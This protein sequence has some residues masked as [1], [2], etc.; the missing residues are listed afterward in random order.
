MQAVRRLRISAS[1]SALFYGSPAWAGRFE[2]HLQA[3]LNINK[4]RFVRCTASMALASVVALDD[5]RKAEAEGLHKRFLA[6]SMVKP[7]TFSK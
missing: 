3:I 4:N 1:A 7:I 2:S 5:K 6:N